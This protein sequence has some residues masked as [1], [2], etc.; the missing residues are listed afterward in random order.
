MIKITSNDLPKNAIPSY[1]APTLNVPSTTVDFDPTNPLH[2]KAYVNFMH[3]K[4]WI[5]RFNTKWPLTIIQTVE[6]TLARYACK[7]EWN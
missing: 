3:E 5:I 6:S 2:R 7:K 4:K 1:L